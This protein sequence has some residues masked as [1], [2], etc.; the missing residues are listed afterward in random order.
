[1]VGI[2][3][4]PHSCL[5]KER[6]HFAGSN[7]SQ[8]LD[9]V[10][11]AH[12]PRANYLG[13]HALLAVFHPLL[14]SGMDAFHLVAG[15]SWFVEEHHSLTDLNL[16]T[17]KVLQRDARG[18]DVRADDSG[19]NHGDAESIGML[20]DLLALNQRDLPF[21]GLAGAFA[22]PVKVADILPNAFSSNQFDFRQGEKRIP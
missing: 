12:L 17:H 2:L 20:P 21:G 4:Q 19:F 9:R 1:V 5:R 14:Q 11:D 13:Q 15:R 10:A 3:S 7:L 22:F 18:F 6:R 8:R 16:M